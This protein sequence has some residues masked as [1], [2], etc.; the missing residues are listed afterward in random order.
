MPCLRKKIENHDIWKEKSI[1]RHKHDFQIPY[2]YEQRMIVKPHNTNYHTYYYLI[3]MCTKCHS[4]KVE[5][6]W[7]K[8]DDYPYEHV[9]GVHYNSF[10]N[11]GSVDEL[12]FP[13]NTTWKKK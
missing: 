6:D 3:S 1:E 9:I 2:V 4:F 12:Y 10:T 13:D 7:I 5:P 8:P 11:V